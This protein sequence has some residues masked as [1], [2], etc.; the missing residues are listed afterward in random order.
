MKSHA[1]QLKIK[2]PTSSVL[3]TKL[4]ITLHVV[5]YPRC[6]LSNYLLFSQHILCARPCIRGLL[7]MCA[8]GKASLEES[9]SPEGELGNHLPKSSSPSPMP[10]PQQLW[11]IA[12]NRGERVLPSWQSCR[13]LQ[14]KEEGQGPDCQPNFCP[15]VLIHP[16][17][18][19]I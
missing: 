4:Q 6:Y 19:M 5:C 14:P 18:P 7:H 17:T 8:E 3:C 9:L 1:V 10:W 13:Y 11:C 12:K 15:L 2:A 16:S